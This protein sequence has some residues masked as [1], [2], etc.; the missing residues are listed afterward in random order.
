MAKK[1]IYG[2]DARILK[3]TPVSVDLVWIFFCFI[4]IISSVLFVQGSG[5]CLNL[6]TSLTYSPLL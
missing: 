2:C 6:W 3:Y 5:Y 4:V 1:V